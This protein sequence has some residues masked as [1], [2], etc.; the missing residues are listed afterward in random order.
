MARLGIMLGFGFG[1]G[2]PLLLSGFTLRQWLTENGVSPGVL[3]LVGLIGWSYTLKFLWAPVLDQVPPPLGLARFGRRRG[4]MLA[5]QPVLVLAIVALALSDVAASPRGAILAAALVAFCSATQDIA[6]DAW[7]IESFPPERQGVANAVYVWGY[8]LGMLV[9]RSG[10]L[11]MASL[12]GWRAALLATA[13]FAAAGIVV[14]VA[15]PEPA[16][17]PPI[18]TAGRAVARLGRAAADSLRDFTRRP[19]AAPILAYVALF[20][21]GE[22]MAGVMLPSLYHALG[23]QR[24]AVAA[25]GPCIL[26]GTMAGISAGGLL[27]ARWGV[28]RGLIATGLFQ[29]AAMA[30]YVWL[31]VAPGD[32]W[33]LFTTTTVEAFAQGCATAAFLA[34]LS[35]LCSTAHTATQFAV[36]TS[37]APLAS[38]TVGSVSGF[39]AEAVG[40]PAFYA[41]AML[42]S[43]P[44]MLLMLHILG[45][46][47]LDWGATTARLRAQT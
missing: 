26:G 28:A 40:W 9:A 2:L 14:T 30:L 19:G 17:P 23:F 44:G 13:A 18:A 33:L 6:I 24:G 15:A 3:G 37:V 43:L 8:R 34:Y 31:A 36:L 47:P 25:L 22:A 29:M 38:N 5:T 41:L 46:Y 20:N 27:V 7:R 35:G 32:H 21:L 39:L 16:V 10:V 42:A 12:I 4:W 1:S 45:R 11:A